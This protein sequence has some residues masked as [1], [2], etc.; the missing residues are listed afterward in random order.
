MSSIFPLG[1]V[2]LDGKPATLLL[3]R[4][5]DDSLRITVVQ[6]PVKLIDVVFSDPAVASALYVALEIE[7]TQMLRDKFNNGS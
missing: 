5:H 3:R 4:L 6:G 2:Q 1:I 7:L